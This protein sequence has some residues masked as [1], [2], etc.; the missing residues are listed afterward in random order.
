[1]H[2]FGGKTSCLDFLYYT[3]QL[4]VV[5]E[6]LFKSLCFKKYQ[7]VGEKVENIY[8]HVRFS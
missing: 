3:L 1:M 8:Q 6:R 4:R 7:L 5:Y 2:T